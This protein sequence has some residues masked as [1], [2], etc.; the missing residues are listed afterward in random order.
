MGELG[1]LLELLH[2]AGRSFRTMRLGGT[3]IEIDSGN[4]E[5]EALVELAR[6]LVVAPTEPPPL[7]A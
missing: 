6:S 5:L 3:A 4:V 1:D 7:A 2:G